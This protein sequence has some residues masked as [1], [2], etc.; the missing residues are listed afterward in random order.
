[1]YRSAAVRCSPFRQGQA[2]TPARLRREIR[3]RD[4][5]PKQSRNTAHEALGL[6]QRLVE[7]Y[8][9]RQALLNRKI[10]VAPLSTTRGSARRRPQP[11]RIFTNP[12][13]QI[14]TPPQPSLYLAQ[15]VTRWFC[16]WILSRRSA[17]NLYGIYSILKGTHRVDI[18][19]EAIPAT[20]P[21]TGVR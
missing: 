9:Q 18:S 19:E 5:D 14:T 8:A 1:M 11:K 10:R 13:R 2:V 15:L 21:L 6:P 16:F 20:T 17:L 7:N 4:L 12:D 3:H